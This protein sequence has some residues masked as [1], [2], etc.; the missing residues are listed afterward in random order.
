[1][2]NF[3][4]IEQH[5]DDPDCPE[6]IAASAKRL[7]QPWNKD[8]IQLRFRKDRKFNTE[9]TVNPEVFSKVLEK[10]QDHS[11]SDAGLRKLLDAFMSKV[12]REDWERFYRPVL[13]RDPTNLT[14]PRVNLHH[15]IVELPTWQP[16]VSEEGT[17]YP[18]LTDWLSGFLWLEDGKACL[19]DDQLRFIADHPARLPKDA[20]TY[21]PLMIEIWI[22][23]DGSMVATDCTPFLERGTITGK[24]R[25]AMLDMVYG[26]LD[27]DRITLGDDRKISADTERM[28]SSWYAG[29]GYRDFRLLYKPL[30]KPFTEQGIL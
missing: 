15:P 13:A 23:G 30:S 17:A 9:G 7:V 18:I 3:S 12:S 28:V 6:Y 5:L 29:L 26:L 19:T 4:D 11:L 1:M 27:D 14:L 25:K 21:G 24:H 2:I 22:E 10:L 20:F 16:V 8:Q